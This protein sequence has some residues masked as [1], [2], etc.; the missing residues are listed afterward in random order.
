MVVR[1]DLASREFI[2]FWPAGGRVAAGMNVNVWD[3][4]P[5]IEKLIR[6]GKPV[7]LARLADPGIALEDVTPIDTEPLAGG[8]SNRS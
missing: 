6:C 4:T 8:R 2:A 7:D 1:G 3:V 5:Q